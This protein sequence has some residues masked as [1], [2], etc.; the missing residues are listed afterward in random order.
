MFDQISCANFF[1]TPNLNLAL[2]GNMNKRLGTRKKYH[3]R[4]KAFQGLSD[5][6]LLDRDF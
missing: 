1:T 3:D 2:V 5:K 4:Q 6:K